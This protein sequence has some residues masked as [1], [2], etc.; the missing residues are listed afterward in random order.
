MSVVQR[1]KQRPT[2]QF[3]SAIFVNISLYLY[4]LKPLSLHNASSITGPP[5]KNDREPEGTRQR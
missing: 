1:T 4:H 5:P 3:V 2:K